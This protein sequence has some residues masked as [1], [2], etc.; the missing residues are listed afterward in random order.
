MSNLVG[1]QNVGFLIT[2]LN[3]LFVHSNAE[4]R[5]AFLHFGGTSDECRNATE[6]QADIVTDKERHKIHRI[7]KLAGTDVCKNFSSGKILVVE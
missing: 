7:V 5:D 2:R 1:Y 4:F 6:K 3:Y